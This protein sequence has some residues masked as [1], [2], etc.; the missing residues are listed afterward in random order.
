MEPTLF[1]ETPVGLEQAHLVDTEA[2]V[3]VPLPEDLPI[4]DRLEKKTESLADRLLDDAEQML[5]DPDTI[6][7]NKQGMEIVDEI[8]KRKYVATVI[9]VVSKMVQGKQNIKLKKGEEVRN[10]TSFLM[11][12][13]KQAQAGKLDPTQL[14][15]L[16]AKP[17]GEQIDP[18]V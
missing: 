13:L 7:Y 3:D 17:N 10:N 18:G 8:S 2:V 16:T 1:V 4:E 11:D 15:I 6:K 12:L 9:G 5:K 14:G